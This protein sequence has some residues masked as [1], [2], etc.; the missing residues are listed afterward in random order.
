[1]QPQRLWSLG[2]FFFCQV[3]LVIKTKLQKPH[4]LWELL[5]AYLMLKFWVR[6]SMNHCLFRCCN[7]LETSNPFQA[8][9]VSAVLSYKWQALK[10]LPSWIPN[11]LYK[12]QGREG[13]AEALRTS[14]P[15]TLWS[16]SSISNGPR[17][18]LR[19]SPQAAVVNGCE[20]AQ[21]CCC[22]LPFGCRAEKKHS[23]SA[24]LQAKAKRLFLLLPFLIF[25]PPFPTPS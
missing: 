2:Y 23:A 9:V 4:L 25:T 5:S 11:C 6:F 20:I 17:W 24:S 3:M 8:L 16:K 13:R 19:C 10:Y 22:S 21:L 18:D 14:L 7:S 15:V 1:M 12:F